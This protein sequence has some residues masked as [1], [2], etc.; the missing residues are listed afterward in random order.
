MTMMAIRYTACAALLLSVS[1]LWASSFPLENLKDMELSIGV[2]PAWM[3]TDNTR[4]VISSYE[5][6]SV[7]VSHV[8]K[9]ALW[10]V[11]LGYHFFENKLA[12]RRFFNDL[13]L[14]LNLYRSEQT[15]RGNVWQ[16]QY[17]QFNNYR[18]GVPLN[19][20]R[21]MLDVKPS[22]LTY[23]HVSLYPIVGLGVA[24]NKLSYR[25]NI[26]SGSGV[27]ADSRL[28]L[29]V[30]NDSQFAYDFGAGLR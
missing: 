30:N 12:Q 24:W 3:H 26:Q 23:Y 1:T 11:G 29:G 4:S 20:V 21:L 19:S 10:K 8:T 9:S 2:G 27:T 28:F 7:L 16:Y 14:Q 25:E 13:L 22:L 6:D 5:T 15:I 18:F 17:S